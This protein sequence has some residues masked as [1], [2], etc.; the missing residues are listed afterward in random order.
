L[1]TESSDEAAGY[2]ARL[3]DFNTQRRSIESDVQDAAMRNVEKML[4]T[5]NALPPYILQAGDG[6]HAGVIGIVAGRLKD[7]YNR[8][9]FVI[10]FDESGLGK[11]SARSV[12][13]VDVGK[14]VAG[15]VDE[16]LIEAGGGHAMA[17]G[18]T[19]Q[20]AQLPAFEAYLGEGPRHNGDGW[21]AT[22][23]P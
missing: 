7:K 13:S 16:K 6:W 8:P 5:G 14:L 15:A 19:L 1:T 17:A 10:A 21:A 18:V 3:D 20:R 12:S 2:A 9:S 23:A 11:G 4:E 22:F